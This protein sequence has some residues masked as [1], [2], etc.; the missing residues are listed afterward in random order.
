MPAGAA[1]VGA[2]GQPQVGAM[3]FPPHPDG[4]LDVAVLG[5]GPAGA[6]AARLLAAWGYRVALLT[7]EPTTPPLAES[8]P[9]SIDK[10]FDLLGVR[11]AME[12]AGFVRTTGNTVWWGGSET[13]HEGF[14]DG[15]TGYQVVQ[16][17]LERVLQRLAREAGAD[18]RRDADVRAVEGWEEGGGESAPTVRYEQ[19]GE[20]DTVRSRWVLDCTGRAGVIA[21]RG[22]RRQGDG[23]PTLALVGVWERPNGWG[24]DEE[25]HTLV[26]SYTDG[27]AW[28]VPVSG[29][30]R[31][32]TAMVDPR[33]TDLDRGGSVERTY[34][35]E[36]AKTVHLTPLVEDAKRVSGPWAC[37]AATYDAVRYGGPGYLLVGDAGSFIDPLSSFGVKKA[38]AS[39]WLAAVVVNTVLTDPA[40][41]PAALELFDRRER[42]IHE[43]YRDLSARFAAEAGRGHEHGFWSVRAR[44]LDELDPASFTHEPDARALRE[45]PSVL[46]AFAALKES[47]GLHLAPSPELRLTETPTVEGNRVVL[48]R[49]LAIPGWDA[50]VRHLRGIDLLALTDL[51][52]GFGQVPDL[53]ETFVDRHGPVAL[54]DFLGALSVLLAKGALVNR[55]GS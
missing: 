7:R 34:A 14:A 13:R 8:L 4:P 15:A 19:G 16:S 29:A 9:P 26:E 33:L 21:K 46:A 45:D 20:P 50:G 27:W 54:P 24:L 18:L 37:T 35:A 11:G 53:F 30:L 42:H 51:A 12:D 48:E 3:P 40:M 47:E 10:V 22:L 5:G 49:R 31:Y 1:L 36:L 17:D 2:T 32:F 52:P 38:M 43:A 23:P 28:S 6:S 25:T 39:A 44:R 41:T 55:S